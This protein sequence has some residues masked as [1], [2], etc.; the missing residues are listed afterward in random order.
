MLKKNDIITAEICDVTNLGYGVAHHDGETVFVRSTV[1]GDTVTATVIKKYPT[2]AIAIPTGI[3]VP[4]PYRCTNDCLSYPACGGCSYRHIKYDYELQL[5]QNYVRSCF[6]KEGIDAN[7]AAVASTSVQSYR[8]K[9]QYP[10]ARDSDGRL[11]LG[12]YSEYSHRAVSSNG[13]H[14]ESK[15]FVPVKRAVTEIINDLGYSNYDEKSGKGLLRHVFLRC[16]KYG[17]VHV[18]FVINSSKLPDSKTLIERLISTC[19]QIKGVSININTE[20]T[21]VIL[22]DKTENLWGESYL[23][24]AICDKTFEISPRSFWQINRD[25][26]EALYSKGKELLN[27]KNGEVLLDLYCG[28]G[29]IGISVSEPSTNLVGVEIIPEAVEDAKRNARN[30]GFTNAHFFCGDA[31]VGFEKCKEIFGRVDA[32]IVD[33]PRKGISAD[34]ADSIIASG[35]NKVLYISCNPATL[36]RDVRILIDGGYALSQVYP[37]DMF[38]RTGHVESLVCLC[39]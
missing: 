20:N 1:T 30:N 32:L 31:V 28:I 14:T 15:F 35:V 10:V 23:T 27:I 19:P 39:K 17:D 6:A 29:S 34:S 37:F 25:T 22:G 9:V 13:C 21:N 12:F 38:P 18:C 16:N 4:S 36:A 11:F 5:K 26:A 7:V 24:D 2:Y 3:T 33:P 8:N